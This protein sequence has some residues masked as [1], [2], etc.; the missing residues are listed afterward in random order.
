[1]RARW[2]AD[3]DGP[4]G[5]AA[6]A[7]GAGHAPAAAF[8][9]AIHWQVR[10]G[11][12]AAWVMQEL[13]RRIHLFLTT[14]Q[15]VAWYVPW[16]KPPFYA[17]VDEQTLMQEQRE[18]QKSGRKRVK[19]GEASLVGR[20]LVA[21]ARLGKD[22]VARAWVIEAVLHPERAAAPPAVRPLDGLHRGGWCCGGGH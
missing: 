2:R 17:N 14:P 21:A 20:L 6:L 7:A 5:A 9:P 22:H 1:M 8:E 4:A 3:P 13:S 10:P 12:G 18:V 19:Q 11:D 16:A 15:A